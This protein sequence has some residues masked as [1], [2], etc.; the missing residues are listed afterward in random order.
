M[1]VKFLFFFGFLLVAEL[2]ADIAEEEVEAEP[3]SV[4]FLGDPV[5]SRN[6]RDRIPY[7]PV[8]NC[9]VLEKEYGTWRKIR[10]PHAFDCTRFYECDDTVLLEKVCADRYRTRYDPAQKR[11]EWNDLVPCINYKTYIDSLKS[12]NLEYCS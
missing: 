8:T 6:G 3:N 9:T 4:I 12:E 7:G 10:L 1:S 2:L 5:E 11:C